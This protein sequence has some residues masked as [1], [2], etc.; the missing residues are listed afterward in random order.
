MWLNWCCGCDWTFCFFD[1]GPA[2]SGLFP[3][4]LLVVFL[5]SKSFVALFKCCF[6]KSMAD[7]TVASSY[8]GWCCRCGHTNTVTRKRGWNKRYYMA[9][10]TGLWRSMDGGGDLWGY[11]WWLEMLVSPN[12]FQRP[13]RY[14]DTK[15]NDFHSWKLD[16][17]WTQTD[18]TGTR[19]T[20]PSSRT[21]RLQT[22]IIHFC[23]TAVNN[24]GR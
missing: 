12:V 17:C 23:K 13:R 20:I 14:N 24:D 8:M 2:D 1:I 4:F 5:A 15:S 3:L 18:K 9:V 16:F 22:S 7:V 21:H 11:G 6:R 10:A 19:N